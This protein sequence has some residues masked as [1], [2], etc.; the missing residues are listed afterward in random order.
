MRFKVRKATKNW[1]FGILK[2]TVAVVDG[3]HATR[4]S[5]ET[6]NRFAESLYKLDHEIKQIR[7]RGGSA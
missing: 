2:P 3:L 4:L 6:A 5:A 7:P 1:W